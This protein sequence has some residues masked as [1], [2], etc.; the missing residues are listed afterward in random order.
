MIRLTGLPSPSRCPDVL[1]ARGEEGIAIVFSGPSREVRMDVENRFLG[2][3]DPEEEEL[4]L[5]A[6]LSEMGYRV[7]RAP[8]PGPP[9]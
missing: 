1:V 8:G 7:T 6:R 3:A 4:R 5:L 2:D 9:P